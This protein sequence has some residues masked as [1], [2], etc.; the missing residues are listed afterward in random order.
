VA[1]GGH[2]TVSGPL[3]TTRETESHKNREGTLDWV[4]AGAHG[5][6]LGT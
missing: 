4:V 6:G 5:E 1:G 3:P 2:Y